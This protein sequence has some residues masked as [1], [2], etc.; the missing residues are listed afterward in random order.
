M[1]KCVQ[2]PSQNQDLYCRQCEEFVCRD[3]IVFDRKHVDH[4]YDKIEVIAS[5]C[6]KEMRRKLT[7]LQEQ[8][9]TEEALVAV[10][11]A[12]VSVEDSRDVISSKISMSYDT[13]IRALEEEKQKA[14]EK[15]RHDVDVKLRDM[16][17]H[18]ATITSTTSDFRAVQR[19]VEHMVSRVG[20][21]DFLSRNKKVLLQINQIQESSSSLPKIQLDTAHLQG[22]ILIAHEQ[23]RQLYEVVDLF[24]STIDISKCTSNVNE[25]SIAVITLRDSCNDP[26]PLKQSVMVELQSA[27]FG[28]TITSDIVIHS[29]SRYEARYTPTLRTRGHCELLVMVGGRKIGR[30]PIKLFIKCPPHL[31]GEPVH[32]YIHQNGIKKPGYLGIVGDRVFCMLS[33][34]I[35]TIDLQKRDACPSHFFAIPNTIKI[36]SPEMK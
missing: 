3:C 8:S 25:S 18:E 29:S 1:S 13:A 2:H 23:R 7:S 28:H 15:V 24:H 20:D 16:M 33:Q 14:I 21:V 19:S 31:L 30:E 6:R 5:E 10:K 11:A 12:C 4:P 32:M 36:W 22:E 34:A 27:R 9:I 26:C 17:K 35:C